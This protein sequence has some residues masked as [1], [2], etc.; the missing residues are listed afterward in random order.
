MSAIARIGVACAFVAVGSPFH[1]TAQP[2]A[3]VSDPRVVATLGVYAMPGFKARAPGLLAGGSFLLDPG[4]PSP[5]FN[6]ATIQSDVRGPCSSSAHFPAGDLAA[7]DQTAS[8]SWRIEASL[9]KIDGDEATVDLRWARRVPRPGVLLESTIEREERLTLRDGARGI[10]DL[11]RAAGSA[12][13]VCDSFAIAL[14]LRFGSSAD[15]QSAGL[16]FDLWLIDRGPASTPPMR[17]R[18]QGRQGADVDY[19]FPPLKLT[20]AEGPVTV[21]SFGVVTGRAR[22]DGAIDLTFDAQQSVHNDGGSRSGGGRKRLLVRPGE[23]I[24]FE[25][26]DAQRARLPPDLQ[27]RHDFVMRVTTE[28]LW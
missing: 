12:P 2:A 25:L 14:E 18:T 26:P 27:Q 11:V 6:S 19:A 20:G 10:L 23:T 3:D 1:T 28:R 15:E 24:E 5:S 7:F 21:S 4:M 22:R 16:G 17:V 8:A 9:V 13:G